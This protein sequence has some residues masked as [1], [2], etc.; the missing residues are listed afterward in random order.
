MRGSC[1]IQTTVKSTLKITLSQ[2]LLPEMVI[3]EA[4]LLSKIALQPFSKYLTDITCLTTKPLPHTTAINAFDIHTYAWLTHDTH[5]RNALQPKRHLEQKPRDRLMEQ[6]QSCSAGRESNL[7]ICIPSK[8][9]RGQAT[10]RSCK[11]LIDQHTLK[12]LTWLSH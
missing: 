1:L 3:H 12:G 10:N 2:A 7:L 4:M 6:P 11:N 9:L 5:L 8:G